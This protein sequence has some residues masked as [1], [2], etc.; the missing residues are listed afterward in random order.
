[1]KFRRKASS[2]EITGFLDQGTSV[3]GELRFSGTLRIDGS[4]HG[5]IST[6]DILIVGEHGVLHADITTGDLEIHGKIFGNIDGKRR[7]R[8]YSSGHVCGDLRTP[9]LVID[10]G[11]TFDGRSRMLGDAEGEPAANAAEPKTNK[12]LS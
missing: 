3:T 12:E 1:M 11:G 2:E 4:F 7:V 6:S 10:A 9:V 5:S 8:I